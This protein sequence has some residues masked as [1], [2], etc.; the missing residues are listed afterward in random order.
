[1]ALHTDTEVLYACPFPPADRDGLGFEG[2]QDGSPLEAC[3]FL[4]RLREAK[5]ELNKADKDDV[6]MKVRLCP[7]ACGLALS[8]ASPAVGLAWSAK[9][10][11]HSI[12]VGRMAAE[13]EVAA[14]GLPMPELACL[15]VPHYISIR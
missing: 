15:P 8:M 11:H 14:P 7:T 9:A 10:D 3:F 6:M 5:Y 2:V 12:H 1:M 4:G 13:Y